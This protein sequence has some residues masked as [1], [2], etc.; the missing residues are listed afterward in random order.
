MTS[1]NVLKSA[2]QQ[3]VDFNCEHCNKIVIIVI[4]CEK[5]MGAFHP[6]CLKQSTA[7]KN[8]ICVH[9]PAEEVQSKIKILKENAI[10][11]REKIKKLEEKVE[12]SANKNSLVRRSS[13]IDGNMGSKPGSS[14]KS[15]R[16]MVIEDKSEV[17][18]IVGI[19]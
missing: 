17:Q 6:A 1:D 7:S 8:E 9:E 4:R 15:Y 5:C 12:Y 11:L 10:L 2:M 14:G 3:T 13:Q 16:Q 19:F 18:K